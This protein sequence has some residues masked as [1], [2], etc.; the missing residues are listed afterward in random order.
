LINKFDLGGVVIRDSDIE[1]LMRCENKN[2]V[3]DARP[4]GLYLHLVSDEEGARL[5][6]QEGGLPT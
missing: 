4:D 6:R 1:A 5:A 2:I 3:A